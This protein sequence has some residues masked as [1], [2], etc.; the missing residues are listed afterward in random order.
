MQTVSCHCH[1][2]RSQGSAGFLI[3][4]LFQLIDFQPPLLPTFTRAFLPGS[5]VP[6]PQDATPPLQ[7]NLAPH[8]SVH[9]VLYRPCHLVFPTH[10]IT[11]YKH[12]FPDIFLIASLARNLKLLRVPSYLW[13][14]GTGGYEHNPISYQCKIHFRG[15]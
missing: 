5:P 13:N 14:P 15:V 11:L 3:G 2:E 12:H 8:Q 9:T 1:V 7:A 4:A 10:S 6:L